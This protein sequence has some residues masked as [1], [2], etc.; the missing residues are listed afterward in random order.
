M[1]RSID[2]PEGASWGTHLRELR[3]RMSPSA[4]ETL[5]VEELLSLRDEGN[6]VRFRSLSCRGSSGTCLVEVDEPV[7]TARF[8][9]LA[10]IES[11]DLVGHGPARYEYLVRMEL[12]RCQDT[13]DEQDGEFYI[14]GPIHLEEEGLI[15]T[16]IAT[17]DALDSINESLMGIEDLSAYLELLSIGEYNGRNSGRDTLTERQRQ[18]L[19]AAFEHDYFDIPRGVTADELASEFDLDKS[20][21]LEHLRRAERNLLEVAFESGRSTLS[22]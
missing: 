11:F 17:Q 1:S 6:H 12:P 18:I 22:V 13:L 3:L 9:R 15:F 8:D 21:V 7:D 16:A 4:F 5:G 20:T 14:D 19:S 2:D 10:Y